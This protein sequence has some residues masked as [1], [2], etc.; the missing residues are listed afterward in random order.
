MSWQ[1]VVLIFV[2]SFTCVAQSPTKIL[3]GAERAMGGTKAMRSVNSWQ[4]RGTITRS[5]DGATGKILIQASRPNFY[6]LSFDVG[7]FEIE[8][9]YNGKSGWTRDS[10]AGMRTLTGEASVDFQ[11]EAVFRGS[12]WLD[13][14][15]E[16]ARIVAGGKA[17]V[18]GKPANVVIINTAKGANI[19]LIFD[20]V[21][22]LLLVEEF[23]AGDSTRRFEYSDYRK[24]S[25]I[26]QPHRLKIEIDGTSYEAVLDEIKPNLQIAQS[27]YDFP[28][29]SG[30]PLPDIPTLLKELQ[31]NEDKVEN[32]LETYSYVQR[33]TRR[34]LGKDGLLRDKES[35]TFQLSFYKGNRI[36]RLIEKNGKPL[37]AD[38]QAKEDKNAA[39]RVE[40][41]N[42]CCGSSSRFN[43]I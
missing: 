36:R 22:N 25:G 11:A 6:N 42:I 10:R 38:D 18:A 41:M 12:L 5:A 37:S 14:K 28:K 40:Q 9:G 43:P 7:G 17:D 16:K 3:K 21:S 33:S 8:S 20:A 29:L 1:I 39:E 32:L 27:E 19:K 31:A 13:A 4:R 30:E 23:S 15:K 26:D 24:V 35:E 34:E 2:F